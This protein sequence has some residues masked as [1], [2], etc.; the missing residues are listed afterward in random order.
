MVL[1]LF[2]YGARGLGKKKPEF[3]YVLSERLKI[4]VLA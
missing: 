1:I 4:Q 3:L 2:G